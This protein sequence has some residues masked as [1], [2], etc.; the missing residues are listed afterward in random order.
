MRLFVSIVTNSLALLVL[1]N[2]L[3]HTSSSVQSLCMI[4]G[5]E[6][7]L[8]MLVQHKAAM[9]MADNRGWVPLHQAAVQQKRSILEITFSGLHA[10][11]QNHP[12]TGSKCLT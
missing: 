2:T 5:N 8:Q 7:A 6:D 12:F 1:T 3:D 11:A 9:S 10:L 4:T